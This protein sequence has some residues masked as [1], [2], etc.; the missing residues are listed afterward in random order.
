MAPLAVLL[1]GA[2]GTTTASGM[3]ATLPT[4]GLIGVGGSVTAGGM[5]GLAALGGLGL[6]TVGTLQ[7][8]QAAAAE[9]KGQQAIAAYNAKVQEREA[10]TE[11][12]AAL[13]KQRRQAKEATR[14]AS[15]MR[16][17][18][19][20]SGALAGEGTPLL[21]EARQAAESEL[22]NLMIGYQGQVGANR[23]L[24]QAELDRLQGGIYGRR[25]KSLSRAGMI[26]AG[27]SLLTG[28]GSLAATRYGY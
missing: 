14:T 19:G 15:T 28:L 7:S 13:Y 8:G 20:A 22:E 9:A 2:A 24:S 25:A 12:Q 17:A 4:A 27:G 10:A 1:V 26:G 11:E 3:V 18:M 21:I 6:M 5:A 23:A 16:A